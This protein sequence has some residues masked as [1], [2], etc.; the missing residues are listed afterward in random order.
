MF[1]PYYMAPDIS[2]HA[3]LRGHRL[4]ATWKHHLTGGSNGDE[5]DIR[6]RGENTCTNES[7]P[8]SAI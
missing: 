2:P 4:A 1:N 5:R 6:E 7:Q 8:Q 3:T